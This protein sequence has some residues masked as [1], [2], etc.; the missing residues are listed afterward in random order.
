MGLL[1]SNTDEPEI[2]QGLVISRT[3]NCNQ[4]KV[5][6][7]Q[8]IMLVSSGMIGIDERVWASQRINSDI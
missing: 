3:M 7:I 6:T 8:A 4:G 2:N 5:D 1:A